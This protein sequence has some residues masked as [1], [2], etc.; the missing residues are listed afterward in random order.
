MK[1]YK[2]GI[3]GATGNVGTEMLKI[4]GQKDLPLSELRLFA[5]G[6][7]VG[8]QVDFKGE[9]LTVQDYSEEATKDLDAVL[10]AA[11]GD[12][13]RQYIPELVANEV[14]VI[15]NSSAF[16]LDPSVPLVVPEINPEDL[17]WNKGVIANPNCSTIQMVMALAPVHK[18]YQVERVVVSTYQSVS[19]AGAK[20]ISELEEQIRQYGE[21][22]LVPDAFAYPI[23][24]NLIPQID[25]F[26]E[27][28]Y[29]KEEQKMIDETHKIID[30]AIQV[31]PTAVRVPVFR[32]HSESLNIQ[33]KEPVTRDE[34]VELFRQSPG[35]VVADDPANKDYPMPINSAHQ[36]GVYVGRIRLDPTIPN[37][38]NM[39]ISADNVR[40]GA[41]LNA[42]QILEKV[43]ERQLI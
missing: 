22:E 12:V 40:K 41:A 3:I 10:L 1:K 34:L 39:W 36:D 17:D 13:S 43:I 32:S 42:V 27:D 38:F 30:P 7:D 31:S 33:T 8:K 2:L 14:L 24:D 26:N 23:L 19:G 4:L 29:T 35:L 20:G 25:V 9:V 16:R 28:G 15:D 21:K 11:G 18:K 6:P 5:A 37:G